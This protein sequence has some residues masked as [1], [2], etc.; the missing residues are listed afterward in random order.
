[1]M[2][3]L[4][5]YES[6]S[7][8]HTVAPELAAWREEAFNYVSQKGLPTR[9]D[10]D[11]HYTSVKALEELSYVIPIAESA[12]S[13]E[14]LAEVKNL[15][16]PDFYNLVFIDG[17]LNKTLSDELPSAIEIKDYS[18]FKA[19]FTDS[20]EALN[21]AYLVRPLSLKIKKESS[22][23][24]P[25]NF[26]FYSGVSSENSPLVSPRVELEVGER[27]SATVLESYYGSNTQKYLV[28]S[29][30]NILVKPAA[31]LKYSRLQNDSEE[32]FN[33]GRTMINLQK[34]SVL[35]SLAV[36]LGGRLSRH[37]LDIRLLEEG[38]NAEILGIT[39]IKGK[40]HVDNTSVI[41]HVVGN[42]NTN[43][44]YKGILDGE[45]KSA[46][47]GK[48]VIQKF[49]QKANSAQLNN[50]L[51]LSSKAEAD[52]RPCL[53]IYADD[54]KAAHGSTVGQ[55]NADE[56]FYLQSRCISK[57]KAIP[58]LSY[59]FLSEVIYK[60][61]NEPVQKWLGQHLDQAFKKFNTSI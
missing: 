57:E 47:T 11:W 13:H 29:V 46:F 32:A 31:N 3:L 21:A 60:F 9:K 55:L 39:A 10:E 61:N 45:A 33:I 4:S 19:E 2:N 14:L 54:V 44:L 27:A 41:D 18:G 56:I 38:A 49:A 43:Q 5:N 36:A 35:E 50:N 26:V 30:T 1:M 28:N 6:F 20:F 22:V 23:D 59:G 17:V 53:N 16:N 12:L 48:V 25:V 15:L 24:K 51:L 40:Q 37:S 58:M 52:S 8:T 34:D 7:K 42:C